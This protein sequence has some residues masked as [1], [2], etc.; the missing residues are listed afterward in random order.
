MIMFSFFCSVFISDS[1]KHVLQEKVWIKDLQIDG[2]KR[3]WQPAKRTGHSMQIEIVNRVLICGQSN[4]FDP[5]ICRAHIVCTMYAHYSWILMMWKWLK[6]TD[7]GGTSVRGDDWWLVGFDSQ[8]A[9]NWHP[10]NRWFL[11]EGYVRL[12]GWTVSLLLQCIQYKSV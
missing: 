10:N 6:I 8:R 11:P 7:L 5:P 4:L 2:H 9:W 3:A 1:L 12:R